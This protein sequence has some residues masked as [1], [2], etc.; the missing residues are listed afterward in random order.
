MLKRFSKTNFSFPKPI[1]S[2][3]L[4]SVKEIPLEKLNSMKGTIDILQSQKLKDIQKAYLADPNNLRKTY[5]YIRV[6]CFNN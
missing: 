2:F 6:I 1:L 4:S 3:C 5:E